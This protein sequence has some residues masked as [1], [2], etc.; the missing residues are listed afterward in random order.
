MV[1]LCLDLKEP[2]LKYVWEY[3][4]YMVYQHISYQ[5]DIDEK[6]LSICVNSNFPPLFSNQIKVRPQL[7]DHF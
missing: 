1:F 3:L 4:A 5:S 2:L 6:Q 7:S